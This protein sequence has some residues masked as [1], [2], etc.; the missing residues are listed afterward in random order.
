MPELHLIK[1]HKTFDGFTEFYE[2]TSNYTKTKMK[3]ALYRPTSK[4]ILGGII[5]LSGLTC[6]EENFITKAGAQRFLS[7]LGLVIICPDTSPRGLNL[8]QEHESE[9]FGTGASY[10]IDAI[11]EHYKDHYLMYSYIN[12]EVY[13][14]F[15]KKFNLNGNISI[16]G[17]SMGGHGALTIGLKN[18]D[19][20]KCISAFAPAVNPMKQNTGA[21]SVALKGYLGADS[22][23]WKLYDACALIENGYKHPQE[24]LLDQG[25]AD[26]LYP[27]PLL[28]HNFIDACLV[29]GQ[30]LKVNFREDYDHSYYYVSTFIEEHLRYHYEALKQIVLK[31]IH[32][33]R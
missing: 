14:L 6:T 29:A 13:N 23:L 2:H 12:E 30:P 10:Y 31:D 16:M 9:Y 18:P 26:E 15:N 4:P 20:Y 24:I 17:H 25:L 11:T 22:S 32:S 3:L 8:P 7:E 27:A 19:K 28:T 21:G 33:A 1:S 5:W